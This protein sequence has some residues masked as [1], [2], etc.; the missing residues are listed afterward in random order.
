[1]RCMGFPSLVVK[2]PQI[3]PEMYVSHK[4]TFP[5]QFKNKYSLANEGSK[6]FPSNKVCIDR[7]CV[8]SDIFMSLCFDQPA[9]N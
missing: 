4:S 9:N 3:D 6:G 7:C 8:C 5:I 2:D 1:M